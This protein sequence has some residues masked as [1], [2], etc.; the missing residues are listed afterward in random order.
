MNDTAA[1]YRARIYEKYATR[2]QSV[3]E[4]FDLE[5]ARRWGRAYRHYLRGW[6]PANRDARIQL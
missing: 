6:L 5:G 3:P 2:F 1:D 4:V